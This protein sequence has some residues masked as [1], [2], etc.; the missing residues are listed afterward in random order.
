MT[1]EF[2]CPKCGAVIAFDSKHAGKQARCLTCGQKF[3]IPA[4]SFAK[5]EKVK[6]EPEHGG[7]PIPGFYHAVFVETAKMFIDKHNVTT[8][9]FIAAVVCFKFFLAKGLCCVGSITT[10]LIW[11]W[12]FGFYLNTIYQTAYDEDGLPEIYLGTSVTF[13]WYVFQPVVVFLYTLLIVEL[14]FLLMIKLTGHP[15]ESLSDLVAGGGVLGFVRQLL[16]ICG[17]FLFPAAILATAVGKDIALLRPDYLLPSAFRSF[18]PYIT[19]GLFSVATCSVQFYA[20]PY[21]GASFFVTIAYL[22]MN[23]FAQ[24]LAIF[25]MRAIGLYYRHYACNFK[26]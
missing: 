22:T 24:V 4:E 11:G 25:A 17:L 18:W 23:L 20:K 8:L 6:P 16:L 21:T 14:P 5:P 10:T 26:W 3:I 13:L 12:L 9:V 15:I 2:N 19:T 7:K 1:I